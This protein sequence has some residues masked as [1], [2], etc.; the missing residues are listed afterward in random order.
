MGGRETSRRHVNI[1]KQTLRIV[2][3]KRRKQHVT[4]NFIPIELYVIC[5][6]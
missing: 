2:T 6:F 3:D 4:S 5:I 1:H